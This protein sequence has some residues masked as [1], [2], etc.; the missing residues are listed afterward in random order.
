MAK[1]GSRALAPEEK[2]RPSAGRRIVGWFFTIIGIAVA[3]ALVVGG[4]YV[5]RVWSTATNIE[6]SDTLLPT[7]TEER[8]AEDAAAPGSFNYVLMGSDSRGRATRAARTCSC[9][10]TCRPR[11]TVSSSS[12]SP[13]TCGSASPATA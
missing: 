6:R 7:T 5:W 9:W 3:L 12:R 8:P 2:K 4:F 11:T 13:A 10:P 1:T